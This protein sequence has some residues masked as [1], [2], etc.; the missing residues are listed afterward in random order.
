VSNIS[1]DQP[2][3]LWARNQLFGIFSV[4]IIRVDG[5]VAVDDIDSDSRKN[6]GFEAITDAVDDI[7]SKYSEDCLVFPCKKARHLCS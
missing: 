1:L 3:K 4:P 6:V 5:A 2:R 7:P